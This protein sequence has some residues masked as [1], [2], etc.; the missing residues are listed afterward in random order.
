MKFHD[1][2]LRWRSVASRHRPGR[3]S[4][5]LIASVPL[6]PRRLPAIRRRPQ[7]QAPRLIAHRPLRGVDYDSR[8]KSSGCSPPSTGRGHDHRAGVGVLPPGT[9]SR[10]VPTC[11]ADGIDAASFTPVS[12]DGRETR[13]ADGRGVI[14]H[15]ASC[16]VCS[17]DEP[18][19][20]L[21]RRARTAGKRTPLT[22]YV[23]L[24]PRHP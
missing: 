14:V 17:V 11:A 15:D 5:L 16:T 9:R 10:Y 21:V 4:G 19:C 22:R 12:V 2:A 18:V 7:P 24:C 23:L 8:A 13:A 6:S 3:V 1:P 20:V